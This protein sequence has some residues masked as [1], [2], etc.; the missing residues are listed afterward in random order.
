M[1]PPIHPSSR[2][3]IY[4]SDVLPVQIGSDVTLTCNFEKGDEFQDWFLIQNG[5][6]YPLTSNSGRKNI[7]VNVQGLGMINVGF[8]I[9]FLIT[10]AAF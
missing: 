8:V 5:N 7:K 1:L 9:I 4:F 2:V 10:K 6:S 3:S